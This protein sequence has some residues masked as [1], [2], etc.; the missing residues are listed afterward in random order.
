LQRRER[1]VVERE[2]FDGLFR[3]N[4]AVAETI[5][6]TLAQ[7]QD[8]LRERREQTAAA[9]TAERISRRLLASM[10]MIFGF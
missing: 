1:F 2:G 3:S 10:R 4:P 8:E 7:R 5:S 9:E 6:R